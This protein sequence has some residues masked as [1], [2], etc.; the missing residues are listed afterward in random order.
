VTEGQAGEPQGQRARLGQELQ[1]IR[2]LAGL[3]GEQIGNVIGVHKSTVSRMERGAA[4]PSM[5]QVA[6]WADAAHAGEERRALVLYLAEDVV[7]EV[8]THQSRLERGLA[9]IQY[10]VS[11]LEETARV[12]RHFQPCIVPGLLQTAEY[13]RRILTMAKPN[14]DHDSIG[15]A[16][17]ARLAR[18]SR[19]YRADRITEFLVT[20]QSLMFRPGPD[21]AGMLTAQLDHLASLVT[22]ETVNFGV[23]PVDAPMFAFP[24]CAFV[25]YEERTDDRP[26]MAS[27]ETPHSEAVASDPADVQKYRD[28]LELFRRSALTGTEAIDFVR[29]IAHPT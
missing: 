8:I 17:A 12:L 6:A 19:L 20:E 27:V 23:I 1:R 9:S 5:Q 3:S 21:S 4:V 13:A 10:E 26:A 24:R 15:Q 2:M 18:Q 28:Q 29:S 25:L 11:N 14:A 7:N 22:L 16:V